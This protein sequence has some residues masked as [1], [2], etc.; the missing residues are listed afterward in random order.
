MSVPDLN[1]GDLLEAVAGIEPQRAAVVHG[2]RV[3]S[4]ADLDARS[5]RL[6]RKL[7]AAGLTTHSKV[8]FYLRNSPA[9]VELLTACAKGRFVHANVNYR[10]VDDELFH[11]L[12]NSDSEAVVYDADFRPHMLSLRPRLPQ[13]RIFLE[14]GDA[15][16]SDS[17]FE[18]AC[19]EGDAS[20][21][22][23]E[24]SGEDLYF[25][26]T[27]GTT[28]YPKGV[29]WQHRERIA[30]VG[31]TDADSVA[32]HREKV[33]RDGP[34]PTAMP[35]CPLMHSTGFTTAL[36]TLINGGTL[37]LLPG[38]TFDPGE[39]LREIE[40]HR[41]ARLAIVGDA[42]SVPIL[43]Y[44][45]GH[46]GAHDLS[47]VQA[48]T[49]AG[50]MWSEHCKRGLLEH[51]P[52]A[53]L[54]DSLGSS[55][56]SRLGSAITR[57]GETTAT[58]SFLVGD[59]VKV[60]TEDFREVVPG[61]GE[62]GMIAKAG[63]LPL[64]YY[65]DEAGTARTFP[66][67]DGVRYSLAGDWCRIEADGTMTLLGRGNNCINTGGEKVYPEEVEE[68]LKRSPGIHDAAV[69]GVPD[70]RWGQAVTAVVRTSGDAPL[71]EPEVRRH[72]DA[73]LARYKHPKTI[74]Q[75]RQPLRHENGKV[76]YRGVRRL[77]ESGEG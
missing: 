73:H 27:G 26:Y 6:A 28:G 43:D 48:I 13:V 76:N 61:S 64:G 8:A 50:A 10:Y 62:A 70:P 18:A 66:V 14:V 23:N 20:P 56:G 38:R 15:A 22:G 59:N 55:E 45:S 9:Y 33:K 74:T 65:K 25:M 16:E 3:L 44:L 36:A 32:A 52:N 49:S 30:A 12:D 46:P 51:F 71:N 53:T 7:A 72:L 5:N 35:A 31:I 24:R 1:F 60:F 19:T 40:R 54:S 17:S 29:M 47:S 75:V 41:V 4:W 77:L 57:Q 11:V 68:V 2:E 37:V 34:G 42:F 21:L 39:C 58:A 67:V 63:A 69:L